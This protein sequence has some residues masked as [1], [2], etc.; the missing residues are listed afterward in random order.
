MRLGGGGVAP[1]EQANG[2]FIGKLLSGAAVCALLSV[3][4]VAP[5]QQAVA[6][7]FRFNTVEIN[8]NQRIGDA[9]ILR[10][11]GISRGAAVSGGQL[12]DAFQNL[13][14][15]GLFESVEIE[16][17]GGT[18]VSNVVELPT[19][20]RVRFEGNRRI[21]DEALASIGQATE[22]RVFNPAQ[23]ESDAAAIAE[24]YSNEGRIAA[25]VQPRIIRLNQ[26][27]VNLVFEVFEGDNVEG[28][29][30]HTIRRD[31]VRLA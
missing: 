18:L 7:E 1:I 22:R 15:S 6:Q 26:N 24:A 8:G 4:W 20:N 10:E 23:A 16:P 25:R 5:A 11:A 2:N 31:R 19:I 13:Q 12:N 17:R 3:A 28:E 14:N 21:D 29:R 30:I 27:R 9:A